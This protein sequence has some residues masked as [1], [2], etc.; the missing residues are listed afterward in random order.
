ML[1]SQAQVAAGASAGGPSPSRVPRRHSAKAWSVRKLGDREADPEAVGGISGW[2]FSCV[3][4]ERDP[5]PSALASVSGLANAIP[6]PVV[7]LFDAVKAGRLEEAKDLQQRVSAMRDVMHLGPTLTMIQ[8]TLHR[9]GVN[10]G[11]P[12]VPFVEPPADLLDRA[13]K[14]LRALGVTL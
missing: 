4:D 3:R 14:G 5:T 8:A 2:D 9:R 7:K 6:E 1:S 11:I 12:R 10:A 13:I